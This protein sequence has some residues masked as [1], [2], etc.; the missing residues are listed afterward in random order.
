MPVLQFLATELERSKW[1]NKVLLNEILTLLDSGRPHAETL[2][3][4][5]EVT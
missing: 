1:E 4:N 3:T 5:A 2:Q